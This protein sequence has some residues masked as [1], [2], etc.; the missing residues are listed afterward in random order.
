METKNYKKDIAVVGYTGFIGSNLKK[1]YKSNFNFNSKNISKIRKKKLDL[2]LCAGTY[3]K[4]WIANKYP[5]KDLYNIL[6]LTSFLKN[7]VTKRFVL[8]STIEVY[9]LKNN[10]NELDKITTKKNLS[11]GINRLFLEKFVKKNFINYLIIRLP[12]VYGKNF[13]KNVI[14]DLLNNNIN[15]LN[16]NDNI[17]IYNVKNLKKDIDFCLKNNIKEYNI[18]CEPISLGLIAKQIF[19]TKLFK[20][21]TPRIMN[22]KSIYI[23]KKAGTYLY[24]KKYLIKELK[25]FIKKYKK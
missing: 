13:V 19:K 15:N 7:I 23:K 2:V 9:G 25:E 4:R 16:A 14:Y 22:M 24:Q 18:A 5:K 8:I 20:K 3:S 11:Y 10:K 1:I 17:Q 6:K 12:I 21:K